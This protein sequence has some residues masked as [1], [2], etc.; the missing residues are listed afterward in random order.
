MET[1]PFPHGLVRDAW[2]VAVTT[3]AAKARDKFPALVD[4]IDRAEHLT[5]AGEVELH[6]DGSAT[7]ASQR[8]DGTTYLVQG[9]RCSCPRGTYAPTELCKHTFAVL[10]Y[11][12][13][14]E[15]TKTRVEQ[16]LGTG[17]AAS[18]RAPD[19]SPRAPFPLAEE[20]VYEVQGVKAVLFSGLV[21]L[22]LARGLTSVIVDVVSVSE[23]LAVMRA[24]VTFRDGLTWTDVGDASPQNVG[25]R[26]KPHF[27]RMAATRAMARCLRHALDIPYVC[28]AE[29]L[30]EED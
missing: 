18:E 26:I 6:A 8:D 30:D 14:L 16:A 11:R 20:F 19:A 12:R 21:H 10:I 25:N 7:V 24:T 15:D 17:A 9:Q 28:K 3:A 2:R 27:I 29:L 1:P 23:T 4:A 22:A 5:L 13:A